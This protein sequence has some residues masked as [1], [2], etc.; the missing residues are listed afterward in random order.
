MPHDSSENI[1]LATFDP[2]V[3]HAVVAVLLRE[4]VQAV[5]ASVPGV[6][7]GEVAV[8]VEPSQRARALAVL[9]QRMEDV[10]AELRG[11]PAGEPRITIVT[12]PGPRDTGRGGGTGRAGRPTPDEDEDEDDGPPLVMER[13]RS[14]GF[15][16]MVLAPLLVITLSARSMSLTWALVV[17]IGGMVALTAW[18]N[19]G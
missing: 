17:F 3:A 13:F 14:M 5:T 19:R 12:A 9:T 10:S 2:E 8:L 15:V 1:Q 11:G 16:A 7:D 4:G 18:R 6:P